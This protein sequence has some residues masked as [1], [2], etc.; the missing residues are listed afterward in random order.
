MKKKT[1]EEDPEREE[2]ERKERN[3]RKIQ[4]RGGMG[5]LFGGV[6][7]ADLRSNLK[8]SQS[9]VNVRDRSSTVGATP[10]NP[11][12]GMNPAALRGGLKS[13]GGGATV[14]ARGPTRSPN[15]VNSELFAKL[16]KRK[17]ANE[18]KP[19]ETKEPE[20]TSDS[21]ATDTSKTTSPVPQLSRGRSATAIPKGFGMPMGG[22][23][24]NE[25]LA[26]LKRRKDASE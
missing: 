10:F 25:L 2:R 6:N 7:P 17:E 3:L 11:L 18:A 12:A 13:R 16:N 5:G 24:D 22:G 15:P 4:S 20:K 21:P 1:E 23:P 19:T 8:S 26:K 14:A 9:A